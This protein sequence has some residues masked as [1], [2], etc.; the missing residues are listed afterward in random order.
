MITFGSSGGHYAYAAAGAAAALVLV[1]GVGAV[2][3]RPLSRV[4]ENSLKLT[5]G[6]MVTSFGVFYGGEGVGIVWP[7]S[8]LALLGVIAFFVVVSALLIAE[9]RGRARQVA[10][11]SAAGGT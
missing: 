6:I 8:D 3:H 4:P 2:V 9:L 11:G 5:V 7:G 1:A 10:S